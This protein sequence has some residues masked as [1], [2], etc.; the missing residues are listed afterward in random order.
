[1]TSDTDLITSIT[2]TFTDQERDRLTAELENLL[3]RDEICEPTLDTITELAR[4]ARALPWAVQKSLLALRTRTDNKVGAVLLCNTPLDRIIPAQPRPTRL[5]NE[6]TTTVSE[7]FHLMV[8]LATGAIPISYRQENNGDIVATL[9]PKPGDE[10]KQ[11]SSGQILLE[12]HGEDLFHTWPPDI[13]TLSCL[14]EDSG[15]QVGTIIAS[16]RLLI[17]HLT[18]A[19]IATGLRP[20][21]YIDAPASFKG[22][23]AVEQRSRLMPVFSGSRHDLRIAYDAHAMHSIEPA[24]EAF[25]QRLKDLLRG[26]AVTVNLRRGDLLVI[27]NRVTVHGRVGFKADMARPRTTQRSFGRFDFA[28]T[29]VV[30]RPNSPVLEHIS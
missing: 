1:M 13:L 19:E 3:S 27:D 20:I 24:G 21:Y 11:E 8:I 6:K 28:S 12:L 30:R 23:G 25:L 26:I 7:A 4:V 10:D 9:F 14:Q 22:L 15:T 2:T 18:D 16:N 5:W 17:P 29:L